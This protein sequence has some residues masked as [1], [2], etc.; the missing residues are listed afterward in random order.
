MSS[1]S[2]SDA[3]TLYFSRDWRITIPSRPNVKFTRVTP[4]RFE[5]MIPLITNANNNEYQDSKDKIWDASA[6]EEQLAGL[7]TRYEEGPG[8]QGSIEAFVELD[9]K[10]V[11]FGGIWLRGNGRGGDIGVVLNEE[12]RGKGLGKLTVRY[13]DAEMSCF[14]KR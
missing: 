1:G 3:R 11:G 2:I 4:A 7:A 10:V 5:E 12:G 8:K 6:V 9:G 13:V 14:A